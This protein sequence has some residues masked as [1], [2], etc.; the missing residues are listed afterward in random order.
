MRDVM[1]RVLVLVVAAAVSGCGNLMNLNEKA[2]AKRRMKEL[3]KLASASTAEA[4]GRLG[5]KAVGD[6]A[7]ADAAAGFVLVHALTGVSIPAGTELD[8]RR[9]AEVTGKVKVTR[10]R[11]GHFNAADVLSGSPATGDAVIPVGGELP[12]EPVP[13]LAAGA[14]GEAG[15]PVA[16]ALVEPP[17]PEG[18]SAGNPLVVEPGVIRPEDLPNTIPGDLGTPPPLP[19]DVPGLPEGVP[20]MSE[21]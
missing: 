8:C 7:Y 15:K 4:K 10:E 19:V 13:V 14:A 5:E 2:K 17:L 3:E 6:V 12:V 11:K 9:G 21:R 1:K 16:G 18:S 20:P